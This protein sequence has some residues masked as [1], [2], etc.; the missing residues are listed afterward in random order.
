MITRRLAGQRGQG[1]LLI[2]AFVAAFL[3]VVWAALT[4]ASAAFLN[5]NG[6]RSDTRHTYALDAGL[7]YAIETNDSAS[8]GTG[9]T[10]TAATLPLTYGSSTINVIVTITAAPGCKTNKPSYVVNVMAGAG[11]QLNAQI[12]S[13]NAGKKA[14]WTIDWEAFQ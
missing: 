3:L 10:D 6:I 2:L 7:A 13:S 14:S 9:C 11:R 4:L 8:K 1:L 5:L 12:S